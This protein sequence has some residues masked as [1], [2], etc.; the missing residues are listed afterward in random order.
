M[1]LLISVWVIEWV[2]VVGVC[3]GRLLNCFFID[4]DFESVN[5][6]C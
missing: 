6:N 5:V 2:G 3:I 4:I 1:C